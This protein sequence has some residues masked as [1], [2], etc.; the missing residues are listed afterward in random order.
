MTEMAPNKEEQAKIEQNDARRSSE[1]T[2]DADKGGE[3]GTIP[4]EVRI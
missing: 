3:P 1:K 2:K 4:A